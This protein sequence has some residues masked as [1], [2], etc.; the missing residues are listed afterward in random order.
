MNKTH[1]RFAA[2]ACL[3]TATITSGSLLPA[4]YAHEAAFSHSKKAQTQLRQERKETL[5]LIKQEQ[6]NR[7]GSGANAIA[8][9]DLADAV[10]MD[11]EINL[12]ERIRPNGG[13]AT[14][15]MN[16]ATAQSL[17][18]RLDTLVSDLCETYA[19]DEETTGIVIET[20]D[21]RVSYS[22]NPDE[23]YLAASLY[24]LPLAVM[25]TDKQSDE[26]AKADKALRYDAYMYEENSV[27][28]SRYAPGSL[29]PVEELLDQVILTSDN[30]AGHVLFEHL[31]G[32][33]DYKAQAKKRWPDHAQGRD[34][35]SMDN[36]V[37]AGFMNDVLHEIAENPEKYADVMQNMRLAQPEHYLNYKTDRPICQKYGAYGAQL[38]GAGL[39]LEA[40]Y[41]Y[42][43]TIMTDDA[44]AEH[45]MGDLAAGVQKIFDP[46]Q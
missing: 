21:G 39:N 32:W 35:V 15:S 11:V 22:M 31:G 4:A 5:V 25:W 9:A 18:Q 30:T 3:L 10:S 46:E 16:S 36:V 1:R 29:I 19:I 24:K 13:Y 45:F 26:G 2:F 23:E 41:P 7:E 33:E 27:V 34:F 42:V 6:E 38:N 17:Q 14:S 40:E 43:I 37:T 44:A 20:L 8:F 12:I 28:A